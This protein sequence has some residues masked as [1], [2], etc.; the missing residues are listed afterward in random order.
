MKSVMSFVPS[1]YV[2][3]CYACSV[4]L[5]L[6][7]IVLSFMW[8]HF[9][10]AWHT[11][12]VCQHESLNFYCG[13][14]SKSCL[15]LQDWIWSVGCNPFSATSRGWHI[16]Q[17]QSDTIARSYILTTLEESIQVVNSAIHLLVM[18]RTCILSMCHHGLGNI[19][20]HWPNK[21]SWYFY[22]GV[23]NCFLDQT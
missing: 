15:M 17:F 19:W 21:T 11:R 16:S 9:F 23:P 10:N 20:I 22:P 8:S 3:L 1:F 5:F 4:P 13:D 18:E 7:Y 14:C 12:H 2:I 6:D